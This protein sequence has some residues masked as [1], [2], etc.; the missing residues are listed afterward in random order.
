[1]RRFPLMS[2]LCAHARQELVRRLDH[3][4]RHHRLIFDKVL[5]VV[6]TLPPP[7]PLPLPLGR[8]IS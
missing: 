8:R 2:E 4:Y 6:L 7:L 3:N 5:D 1:M